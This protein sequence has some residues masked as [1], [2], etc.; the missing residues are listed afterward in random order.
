MLGLVMG[1]IIGVISIKGGVGKTT[2][3]SNLAAVLSQDFNQKVLLIDANFSAPNI[4]YHLGIEEFKFG[5][6]DVLAD[7]I[8]ASEAIITHKEGFDVIPA[9]FENRKIY[10]FDLKNKI[11]HLKD[12][13]DIILL[14][15]SPNLTDEILATMVAADELYAITSPDIPTLK[16]TVHAVK[17]ANKKKATIS[18]IILNKVRN[19]SFELSLEQ[20]EHAVGVPVLAVLPD[21]DVILEALSKST[22]ASL[23]KPNEDFSVEYKKLAGA[24]INQEYNDSRLLT[25]MKGLFKKQPK[26]EINRIAYMKGL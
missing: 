11:N 10:V 26:Q 19:K 4:A 14:D 1:K 9:M 22:T 17:A 18:G 23:Y 15:S 5:L 24:L 13:Y 20:I 6:H 25:K 2:T 21:N 3:V 16:C 8:P 12:K 7:K